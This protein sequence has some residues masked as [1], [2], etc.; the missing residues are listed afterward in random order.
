M[1]IVLQIVLIFLGVGAIAGPKGSAYEGGFFKFKIDFPTDFPF[2]APTVYFVTKMYHPNINNDGKV[3]L[4]ILSKQW[5]PSVNVSLILNT[6]VCN[7]LIYTYFK[8]M[9]LKE[10]PTEDAVQPVIASLI[11]DNYPE[12]VKQAKEHT[13]KYASKQE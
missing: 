7:L 10:P 6:L 12:F 11:K 8:V 4:E 9:L 1:Y 5:N 3:C 13:N 2:K